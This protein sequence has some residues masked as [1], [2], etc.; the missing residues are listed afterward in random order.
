MRW[1]ALLLVPLLINP[2]LA[3]DP[4]TPWGRGKA[5]EQTYTKQKVVY[6]VMASSEAP[7]VR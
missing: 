5:V 2:V 3:A 1:L 7:C 6:D 4:E